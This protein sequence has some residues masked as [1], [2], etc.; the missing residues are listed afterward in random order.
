VCFCGG[1][2]RLDGEAAG[3][4]GDS[5]ADTLDHQ[6][7]GLVGLDTDAASA[8]V[9]QIGFDLAEAKAADAMGFFETQLPGQAVADAVGAEAEDVFEVESDRA[10]AG[11]ADEVALPLLGAIFSGM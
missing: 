7:E 2:G 11:P 10:A 3:A 6:G 9:K 5:V 8:V 4:G 1:S